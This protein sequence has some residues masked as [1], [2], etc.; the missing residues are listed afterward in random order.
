M[1][2]YD[3]LHIRSVDKVIPYLGKRLNYNTT[4]EREGSLSA[5][6]CMLWNQ[7]TL[8]KVLT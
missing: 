8:S 4:V 1:G 2:L 5:N 6:V 7:T 3:T